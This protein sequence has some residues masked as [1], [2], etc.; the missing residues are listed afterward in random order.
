ME[1]W[2]AG[3][4]SLWARERAEGNGVAV[5]FESHVAFK[6]NLGLAEDFAV[7]EHALY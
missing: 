4:V 1:H 6:S 2:D 3:G 7:N 5:V